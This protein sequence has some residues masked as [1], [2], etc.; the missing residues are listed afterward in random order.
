MAVCDYC[1]RPVRWVLTEAKGKRT[2]IDPEP[3]DVHTGNLIIVD[4]RETRRRGQK[5]RTPV[6]AVVGPLEAP[7]QRRY[8]SHFATCENKEAIAA[9]RANG[10]SR[11][12]RAGESRP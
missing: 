4:Y 5:V 8:I 12:L 11:R 1:Q 7:E 10:A 3:V 2:P 9:R 6:V